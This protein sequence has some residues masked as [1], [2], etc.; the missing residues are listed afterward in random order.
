[1]MLLLSRSYSI[2]PPGELRG[3]DAGI[4]AQAFQDAGEIAL[5]GHAR[6]QTP[7]QLA[8]KFR[9]LAERARDQGR[10]D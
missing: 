7:M 9:N 2:F 1:M 8:I 4:R 6:A 3:H 10:S 5:N